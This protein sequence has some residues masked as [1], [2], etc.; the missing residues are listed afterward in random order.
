MNM[1]RFA[2]PVLLSGTF[3][4]FLDT[5]LVIVA[6]PSMASELNAS[7]SDTQLVLSI[8]VVAY[9]AALVI[10][11][12]LGDRFGRR[13]V[14]ALGM[15]AFT[16]FSAGCAVAPNV[17]VLVVMRALQGLS[18][19]AMLSPVLATIQAVYEGDQ[20]RRAVL[21]YT[22]TLGAA[23]SMGQV[24][25][26]GLL[27]LDVAGIGWRALFAINI[28]IGLLA[29]ALV[30]RAVP[31][32]RAPRPEPVDVR[33][34][35]VLASALVPLM[36]GLGIG[37]DHGWPPVA[38]ALIGV[39]AALAALLPVVERRASAPLLSGRLLKQRSVQWGLVATLA[40]YSGNTATMLG[41]TLFL[42]DGLGIGAL[43]SGVAYLPI[44]LTFMAATLLAR[45]PGAPSGPR[46]MRWGALVMFIGLT[47]AL[48]ASATG[49][50]PVVIALVLAVFGAGMGFVYPA[51]LTSVLARVRPGDEGAASGVLLTA[52][53]IANALGIALVTAGWNATAS[54]TTGLAIAA[55][56]SLAVAGTAGRLRQDRATS[57][58]SDTTQRLRLL[59]GK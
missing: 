47:A 22:T 32:T 23:A 56:L 46:A 35:V 9:G 39:G 44:G 49:A 58:P 26:G 20:R 8:Y 33:G 1:R 7:V 42:Q 13:R 4:G 52:T 3:V 2:L 59:A 53:Q 29:L 45:R 51:I 30:T 14:F 11:G 40:F 36:L 50:G 21:A 15:A 18:A 25:G 16:L 24:I 10:M 55:V 48:T 17:E 43:G 6:V 38:W 27:A 41:L 19:A 31:E 12:R 57:E 54:V 28:P 34:A 5:F 37:P